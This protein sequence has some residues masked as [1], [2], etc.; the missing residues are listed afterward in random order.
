MAKYSTHGRAPNRLSG[1]VFENRP[2]HGFARVTA[3]L[4]RVQYFM[5]D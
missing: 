4:A 2:V 1:Y 5:E 3:R